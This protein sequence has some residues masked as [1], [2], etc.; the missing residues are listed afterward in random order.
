MMEVDRT[1]QAQHLVGDL[2]YALFASLNLVE[3]DPE[4]V[5]RVR[6]RIER[7]PTTVLESRTF[8]EAYVIVACGLFLGVALLWLTHLMM[9]RRS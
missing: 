5:T 4:F 2:E 9:G 8:W 6:Q 3:P 7:Q 1:L